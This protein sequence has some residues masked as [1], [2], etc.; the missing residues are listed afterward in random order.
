MKQLTDK[1]ILGTVQLGIPYG[2]NNK[3]G[4]PSDDEIVKLLDTAF[5]HG[6]RHLDT[7]DVYGNAIEVISRYHQS[8][9][10]KRFTINNKYS[11][12]E[13]SDGQLIDKVSRQLDSLQV[14]YFDHYLFHRAGDMENAALVEMMGKLKEKGFIR[15]IGVSVYT[16]EEFQQAIN[17]PFISSIQLPFNLLDNGNKRGV[18]LEQ[19]RLKNKQ[20]HVRSVFLQGLFFMKEEN[21]PEKLQ[22]LSPYLQKINRIAAENNTSVGELAL[23]YVLQNDYIDKVLIG[24]ENEKQL[25]ANILSLDTKLSSSA[26]SEIDKIN[27]EQEELLSPVNW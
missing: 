5:D 7:A 24:A 3:K 6:I 22:P 13:Q 9:P 16:N 20:V 1:I 11:G 14:K 19:A 26:L 23:Q 21:L 17:A 10:A 25:E 4:V 8:N 27:V 2:I 12:G 15:N 18:L